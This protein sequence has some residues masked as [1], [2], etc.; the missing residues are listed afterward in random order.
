MSNFHEINHTYSASQKLS[1]N[2]Q[3]HHSENLQVVI[4]WL[5]SEISSLNL[6]VQQILGTRSF[7]MIMKIQDGL[8]TDSVIV[9]LCS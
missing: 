4:A 6:A 3:K 2:G 8:V 1:L 7:G 9:I 5:W